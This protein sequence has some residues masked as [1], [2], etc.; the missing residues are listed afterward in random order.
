MFRGCSPYQTR[1]DPKAHGK[2]PGKHI[3]Y[4]PRRRLANEFH[5]ALGPFESAVDVVTCPI[6]IL[7]A[8]ARNTFFWSAR[9]LFEVGLQENYF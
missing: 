3:R 9:C 6:L 1:A 8:A 7:A 2:Q 5:F 4:A